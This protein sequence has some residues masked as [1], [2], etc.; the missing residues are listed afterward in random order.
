VFLAGIF[1][2]VA[3]IASL[4]KFLAAAAHDRAAVEEPWRLLGDLRSV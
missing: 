2:D 3:L 4:L 1:I